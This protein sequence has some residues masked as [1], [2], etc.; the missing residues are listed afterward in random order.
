M[1][2][3]YN[4]SVT[5]VGAKELQNALTNID[6]FAKQAFMDAINKTAIDLERKARA[7]APHRKGGL[8]NSIHTEP[9]VATHDNIEA[10]VGTNLKYARAQEAGTRGMVIHSHNKRTGKQFTYIGNIP[11]TWYMKRARDEVKPE[12]TNNLSDAM[13]RIIRHV[14]EQTPN[15]L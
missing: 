12:L 15:A 7:Q 4:L 1:T 11:P 8:W 5:V 13:Q 14:T 3:D 6:T 9:A 2:G 10:K